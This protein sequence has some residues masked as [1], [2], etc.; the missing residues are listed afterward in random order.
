VDAGDAGI[1]S[2]GNVIIAAQ[3]IRNADN[4]QATGAQIGVPTSTVDIGAL[5][6]ASNVGAATQ[7]AAAPAQGGGNDRPS[8]IIVEV[9]GYGGSQDSDDESIKRRTPETRTENA[10]PVYNPRG[11][12]RILGVGPLTDEEKQSLSEDERQRL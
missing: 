5:T 4:I 11:P 12:V 6:S 9:L 3:S 2:S 1:Q 7:Q 10:V 8:V